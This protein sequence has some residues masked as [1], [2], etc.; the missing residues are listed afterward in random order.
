MDTTTPLQP[1]PTPTTTTNTNSNH[2]HHNTPQP[3]P[4]QPPPTPIICLVHKPYSTSLF[5]SVAGSLTYVPS[6]H[7]CSLHTNTH[8]QKCENPSTKIQTAVDKNNRQN[9][10]APTTKFCAPQ[11]QKFL[12]QSTKIQKP[13]DII[14]FWSVGAGC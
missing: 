10:G 9:F 8:R 14:I 4:P 11:R 13:D 3:L 2:N 5:A 12:T 1:P 6:S 7:M